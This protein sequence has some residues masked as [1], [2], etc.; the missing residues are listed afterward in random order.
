[1]QKTK[2]SKASN[3]PRPLAERVQLA[4][5]ISVFVIAFGAVAVIFGALPVT[6]A[7]ATAWRASSLIEVTATIKEVQLD[8]RLPKGRNEGTSLL[9]SPKTR[10]LSARYSYVWQ[11]VTHESSRISLQHWPGWYDHALWHQEWFDRLEQARVSQKP[12]SAWVNA[13]GS[14]EAV[15]DKSVRWARLWLA[16]PLL[17]LFGAVSLFF[18][19][20]IFR[21]LFKSGANQAT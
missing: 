10:S 14:P 17:V 21:L 6:D 20:Q 18:A 5:L 11:G 19:V 15:L 9:G 16:V 13:E 7:I 2:K 4:L 8:T 1:M 3:P 12:V